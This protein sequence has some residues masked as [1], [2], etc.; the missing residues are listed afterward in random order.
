M[1][2]SIEVIYDLQALADKTGEKPDH[3]KSIL[4]EIPRLIFIDDK[5]LL[6]G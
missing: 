5:S 1:D 6:E 2:N 3:I 4:K